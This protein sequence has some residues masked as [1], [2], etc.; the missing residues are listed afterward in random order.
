M[1]TM[2]GEDKQPPEELLPGAQ[3]LPDGSNL[4]GTMAA[5]APADLPIAVVEE[6]GELSRVAKNPKKVTPA[7]PDRRNSRD[8]C[9]EFG[10]GEGT[11]DDARNDLLSF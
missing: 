1:A 5:D 9:R 8:E 6:E 3:G 11:M 7:T 2:H 4:E 10:D